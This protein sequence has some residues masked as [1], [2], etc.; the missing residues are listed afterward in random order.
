MHKNSIKSLGFTLMELMVTLSIAAIVMS[1][2]IPSF[3]S[4][5][6]SNRLTAAA[7]QLVT[8]LN[9][10]RSEAVKRAQPVVVRKTDAEWESGWQVFVDVDRSSAAV[11]NVFN[12]NG[13]TTLCEAG[14]DCVLRIYEPLPA[15]FTLRGN[16]NF[17]N[18]IRYQPDGDSNNFGSF[19]ICDNRDGNGI[20]E[21]NTS[22]LVTVN[23]LGRL[24]MGIDNDHDGIPEKDDGTEIN[25]CINP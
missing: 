3:N 13:D 8:S 11:T 4:T 2:G 5:L 22:R 7:N 9:L 19:V 20:P 1:I 15:T 25:S 14:E 12:D 18:F 24:H 10:A 17:T 16:I 23:A 21:P 6:R